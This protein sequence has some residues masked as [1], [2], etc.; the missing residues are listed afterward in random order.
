[1]TAIPPPRKPETVR[2]ALRRLIAERMPRWPETRPF[3]AVFGIAA[4]AVLMVFDI[5]ISQA[6][7]FMDYRGERLVAYPTWTVPTAA[8]VFLAWT[9][10]LVRGRCADRSGAALAGALGVAGALALVI[11]VFGLPG[12]LFAVLALIGFVPWIVAWC[13]FQM[14]VGDLRAARSA[15]GARTADRWALAGAAAVLAAGLVAGQAL[16]EIERRA[17]EVIGGLREGDEDEARETLRL[18]A[19]SPHCNFAGAW[20]AYA[21]A[22]RTEGRG[23]PHAIEGHCMILRGPRWSPR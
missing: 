20:A 17:A 14:G 3:A 18:L 16:F 21:E 15:L 8:F 11:V 6:L 22:V 13:A 10:R 23:R 9:W 5:P 4:P 7:S 19:G 12:S 1:M 2:E